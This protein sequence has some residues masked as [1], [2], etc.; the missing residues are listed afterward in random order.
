[1]W[2]VQQNPE[3][4]EYLAAWSAVNQFPAST[5]EI[6]DADLFLAKYLCHSQY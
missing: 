6:S 2:C 4:A 1:M 3:G 5:V